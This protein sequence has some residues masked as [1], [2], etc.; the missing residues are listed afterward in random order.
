MQDVEEQKLKPENDK[1][2]EFGEESENEET[3]KDTEVARGNTDLLPT[4]E[5]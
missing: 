3:K 2:D 4:V 5:R 1:D